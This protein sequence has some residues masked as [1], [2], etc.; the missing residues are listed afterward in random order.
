MCRARCSITSAP[1]NLPRKRNDI[2]EYLHRLKGKLPKLR[3]AAEVL[4][5]RVSPCV[6]PYQFRD[7]RF[8]VDGERAAD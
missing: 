6:R 8:V 5:T 4:Q 2:K 1:S 7:G 3:R